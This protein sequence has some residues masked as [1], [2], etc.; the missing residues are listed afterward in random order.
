MTITADRFLRGVKRRNSIAES[1][2]LLDDDDLLELADDIVRGY[3]VPI[4][5][6]VRGEYMVATLEESTVVDQAEYNFPDR[7]AGE[8]LRDLKLVIDEGDVRDLGKIPLGEEHLYRTSAAQT[9]SYYVKNDQII[10]VPPP[11]A[12][13]TV[14]IWHEQA[15]S[16]LVLLED[17]A[18][19]V[20][21]AGAVVTVNAVPAGIVAATEIDFIRGKAGHRIMAMDK[22]VLSVTDTTITFASSSVVPT[23][24][25]AGDYISVA[26]TSPVLQIPDTLHPLLETYVSKRS[27]H[28]LGDFEAKKEL[29]DDEKTE[30]RNALLVIEPRNRGAPQKFVN[31]GG[32]LKG[33]GGRGRRGYYG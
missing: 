28:S 2:T 14:E 29:S 17:A 31:R 24:L 18:T 11:T 25:V 1:N 32:L 8:S 5:I 19:V 30:V 7:A 21:V 15:P 13:W 12:V 3:I 27:V 33:R 26:G 20:S 16:R 22:A 4:L 23:T 6:S 9:H 10:L